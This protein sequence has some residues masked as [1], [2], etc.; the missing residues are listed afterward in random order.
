MS[1]H[2]LH[3]PVTTL[4]Y[5]GNL[6]ITAAKTHT[7]ITPR[8]SANYI[9]QADI[10]LDKIADEVIEQKTKKGELGNLT[11]IQH[12]A[13]DK[14]QTWMS[15]ARKTASLAFKGQ[16]V[17]LHEQFQVG[18]HQAHDLASILTRA[19]IIIAG[20]KNA[21]NL[22]ALQ[23]KGWMAADTNAFEAA[24]NVFPASITTREES[25]GD[26]KDA[27]TL[28]NADAVDLYER[29]LTIQNAADLQWPHDNPV[30]AG[31][32]DEFRLNTFPPAGGSNQ[33]THPTA[34]PPPP[35]Q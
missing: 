15:R 12:T 19:D 29:L 21:D 25:K 18:N 4:T 14:I 30:N 5:N 11:T 1:T 8:L 35:A 28:K 27:T 17:K 2:R 10:L 6:I 20:L 26:A 34:A 3:F 7:E 24:R 22:P 9:A 23:S 13:F 31:V 16:D 32:R 33:G